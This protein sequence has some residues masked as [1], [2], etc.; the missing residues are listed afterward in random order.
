[1]IITIT[2]VR[3]AGYCPRGI[4]AWF[5]GHGLDFRDFLRNGIDEEV[6]LSLGDAQA[7]RV[8]SRSKKRRSDG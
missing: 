6:L 3:A 5:V 2:D 8:V 1:M 7:D 4:R